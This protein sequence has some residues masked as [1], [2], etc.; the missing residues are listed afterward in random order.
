MSEISQCPEILGQGQDLGWYS[1]R[2]LL[3]KPSLQAHSEGVDP[4][5][6]G[7]PGGGTDGEGVGRVQD[8]SLSGQSGEV[9]SGILGRVPGDII[10]T[11]NTVSR[12]SCLDDL[13]Y[14]DRPPPGG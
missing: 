11:W 2:N 5:E 6:D 7:G 14:R 9:R 8:N 1:L 13:S 10:N 4:G 12:S 3:T